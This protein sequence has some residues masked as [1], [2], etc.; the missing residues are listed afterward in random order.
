M[1][2]MT[3]NARSKHIEETPT[4]PDNT[5]VVGIEDGRYFAAYLTRALE[6]C[7]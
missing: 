3:Y 6:S 7:K 1:D 5:R 2:M 4:L